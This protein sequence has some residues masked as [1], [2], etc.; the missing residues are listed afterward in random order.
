MLR[1]ALDQMRAIRTGKEDQ[2][3]Q[4]F[5]STYKQIKEA[6][7]R[8]AELG[9]A[10]TEPRLQDL[11]R[12]RQILGQSLSYLT[13]ET[14]LS[15][16]AAANLEEQANQLRDYMARDTFFKYLVDIDQSAKA[17]ED[18]YQQQHAQA[19]EARTAAYTEA[20]A[21]L[22]STPGWEQIDADQQERISGTLVTRSKAENCGNLAIP[23]LREQRAAC[24]GLLSKAIEEMLRLIDGNRLERIEASSYFAGG[25]ESEEQLESALSGLRDRCVELLAKGKK[26]LIQ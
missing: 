26:I 11:A 14:E 8:G 20:L 10:L 3:I 17:L 12:S 13:G 5:N 15:E 4:I 19:V 2:V 23:M 18:A 1:S 16:T 25:I 24:S 6:I 7:K 21:Q 22:R 9:N